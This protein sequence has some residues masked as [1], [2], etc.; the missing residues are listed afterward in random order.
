MWIDLNCPA[1]VVGAELASPEKDWIRL[2]LMNL[3]DRNIDSCEAT[4][5]ILSREDEELGRTVH[6]ARALRGR[7][8]SA[9]S[10]AVTPPSTAKRRPME[11]QSAGKRA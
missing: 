1:E 9:F 7:P 11:R 8:H 6:R 10:M 2:I 5:R 3:T 4:V